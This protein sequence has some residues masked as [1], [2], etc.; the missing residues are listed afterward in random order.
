MKILAIEKETI[1]VNWDEENELLIEEAYRAYELFQE[2]LIREIYFNE[3]EN[4]V[5]ILECD[6]KE[7]AVNVLATLPLVKAGFIS[8]DIM[9][10]HPYPGFSRIIYNYR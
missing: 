8:F 10:L 9:E 4:A 2:G 3:I 5:I 6:S 7:E 1:Q